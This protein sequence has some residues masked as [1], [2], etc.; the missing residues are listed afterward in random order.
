MAKPRTKAADNLHV[1]T[2]RVARSAGL[3]GEMQGDLDGV[4]VWLRYPGIP[5]GV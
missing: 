5:A 4:H 3:V 1:K 2:T